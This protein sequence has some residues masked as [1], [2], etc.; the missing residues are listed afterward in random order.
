VKLIRETL[1]IALAAGELLRLDSARGVEIECE[2][3]RVWITEEDSPGDVWLG[4]GERVRLAGRGLA[5]VEA[6]RSSRVRLVGA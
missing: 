5:L 1:R 2:A 3:G 6:Q 4:A